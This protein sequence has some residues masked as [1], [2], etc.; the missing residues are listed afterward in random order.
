MSVSR[1]IAIVGTGLVGSSCAF[2]IANQE[3]CDELVLIDVNQRRA[4]GEAWDIAQGVTFMSKRTKVYVADYSVCKDIDII[5]FAAGAAPK[6]GETRLDSLD[7]SIK[8]TNSVV[9]EAMKN[10][11]KGIFVVLSNPVD[12]ISYQF[13][14]KSGLSANRIIGTGT[15]IDTARLKFFL[16]DIC[17][18]IDEHSI[19]GCTIGEHGDSQAVVWSGVRIAGVPYLS[20]REKDPKKY[21]TLTLDEI[22]TKVVR[23]G[24]EIYDRK[25]TTYYGIASS[26]CNI[27]K[28]IFNDEKRVLP[29]SAYLNGEYNEK[30]IF[31]GVPVVLGK[32]GVEKVIELELTDEE[33]NKFKLSN[34]VIREYIGKIKD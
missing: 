26:A 5:V 2:A 4:E 8:I 32:N 22:R 6:P 3:L 28:A 11:F 15:S 16:S 30:G 23:A 20:L 19:E 24:W 34:N 29:V 12:I 7:M 18:Q 21:A 31:S 14:K 9:T 10:G 33:S 13:Y 17:D 25:G 1:K 27:I